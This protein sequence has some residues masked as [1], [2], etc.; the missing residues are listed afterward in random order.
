[1]KTKF[2]NRTV[3]I[4]LALMILLTAAVFS[5]C[6]DNSKNSEETDEPAAESSPVLKDCSIIHEP[7]FG[8]VYIKMTAE[9]FNK[10]GFVYG[11]SVTVTFSNGYMLEDIPYYNGYYTRTGVPLLIAYPGYDYIKAAINNSA[12]LWDV[13]GLSDSDTASVTLY[14]AGSYIEI[15]EARDLNYLDIREEYE[16][17]EM[18]ANFRCIE[19]GKMKSNTVFRSASPCDNQHARAPYADRLM[20]EAGVACVID[21]ADDEEKIEGYMAADDFDSPNFKE[22]YENGKVIPLSLN[23]NFESDR[24]RQGIARGLNAMADNDGPFLIH[25]TEGKDRTG[26]VCMLIEAL[27]GAGYNEIVDDYML[28]YYNYYHILEETDRMKFTII[29]SEVLNPMI[30]IVAGD[31]DAELTAIDLSECA[32]KYISGL[33]VSEETIAALKAKLTD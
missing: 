1:M 4:I 19:V 12:D 26:F 6:G 10:L 8:G 15:Q 2:F 24:F 25:C 18:F 21:L 20:G 11:D 3:C 9:D 13:A 7:E 28:T 33:G 30:Q 29:I 17:D 27:C 32:E 5:A 23:M 31:P 14:E 16:S 22:L